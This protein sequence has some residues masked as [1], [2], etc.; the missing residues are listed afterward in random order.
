MNRPNKGPQ[1]WRKILGIL[2]AAFVVGYLLLL[3]PAPY[4]TVSP[5]ARNHPFLWNQDELWLSLETQF[6]AARSVGCTGL[7]P[8]IDSSI[9]GITRMLDEIAVDTLGPDAA[10]YDSLEGQIFRLAPKI[11]ACPERLADYLSV[12]SR[13]R[14]VVKDQSRGWEMDSPTARRRIYRL[15]YGARAATEEVMLQAPVGNVTPLL[16]GVQETSA[17]PSAKILGVTIHSGDIL[18]SRG[19]APT[20]ALIARGNDYPGNFSHVALVHV[21]EKTN[22][23]SIIESHI[24]K[25][26]A[27]ASIDDYLRDKKLRIMILR[28][29]A[30]LPQLIADPFL[31]HKAATL[32]LKNTRTR[33]V[34][35][36]FKMD[37]FDH[38]T[39]FCSEVASA[40]YKTLGI[41]LWMGISHI[42]SPGMRS[43][44]AGFGVEFFE[45]Q[46]PSDLEYDPQLRVV[47]EWRDPETLYKD[48]LDN[49]VIDVMLESAETHPELGYS[50]LMLPFARLSKVYSSLLNI[51]GA[52]GPVPEGMSAET[53]LRNVELSDN[54]VAIKT[55]L[56]LL[57][58]EFR[59]ENGYTPPY[60]EMVKLAKKAKEELH[61]YR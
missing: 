11:G 31:P 60:W 40:P 18:V 39:L 9:L 26:V 20:S 30:D 47:A 59:R 34:P 33:H 5:G 55:R 6:S 51:F 3:I 28:L 15:L 13:L 12:C 8:G 41:S 61:L 44:L 7:A 10:Q 22:R 19:G 2:I 37:Y 23:V 48:H 58:E 4:P 53:A 43:W 49:A 54:H 42:S 14:R 29:R 52:V 1:R 25:G 50:R 17:T 24:E 35:Y 21:E 45:T 56:H 36:D 57:A 38:T 46:E 32:A 16:V 27:I